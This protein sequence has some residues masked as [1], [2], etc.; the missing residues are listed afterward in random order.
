MKMKVEM[1]YEDVMSYAFAQTLTKIVQT[2]MKIQAAK[3]VKLVAK[4]VEKLRKQIQDEFQKE[5][6]DVYA[7]KNDE[8]K[9]VRPEH[10]P[11][12]FDV[13][14]EKKEEFTKA[15]TAFGEK[16]ATIQAPPLTVQT[17]QEVKIT[18]SE[19]ESLKEMFYEEEGPVLPPDVGNLRSLHN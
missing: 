2:P 12:G 13:T 17:L 1:K 7:I 5:I 16:I 3:H 14:A 11:L 18:G 4:L 19:L 9:I 15:Q 8:G 6:V 10:D